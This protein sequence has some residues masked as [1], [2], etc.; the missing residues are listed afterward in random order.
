MLILCDYLYLNL[1]EG[2]RSKIVSFSF[3]AYIYTKIYIKANGF[4][5]ANSM[6]L[7]VGMGSGYWWGYNKLK[8]LILSQ[9]SKS[10]KDI[11]IYVW[12]NMNVYGIW[13]EFWIIEYFRDLINFTPK[14][15]TKY[16]QCDLWGS[17]MF[18]LAYFHPI[19]IL[20]FE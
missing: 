1:K 14:L 7:F 16:V 19:N 10:S 11:I 5:N 8:F 12:W 2:W 18:R 17:Y 6:C 3:F 20:F 15:H 9:R 4:I 13:I